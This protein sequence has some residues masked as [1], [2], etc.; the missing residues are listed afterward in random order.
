MGEKEAEAIIIITIIIII[1][2]CQFFNR[3]TLSLIL[4]A[5]DLKYP[6]LQISCLIEFSKLLHLD[7]KGIFSL[8]RI[9]VICLIVNSKGAN[10]A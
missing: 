5:R 6:S 7:T 3:L 10:F 9:P 8:P 4:E 2:C 1:I